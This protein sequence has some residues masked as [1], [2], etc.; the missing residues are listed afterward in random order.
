MTVTIRCLLPLLLMALTV[1]SAA[2]TYAIVLK[3]STA[4]RIRDAAVKYGEFTSVG[5]V[6]DPGVEK[7]HAGIREKP[8]TVV[9]VVWIAED[10]TAFRRQV[11]LDL[12]AGSNE[13]MFEIRR[14]YSVGVSARRTPM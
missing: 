5:G 3:N 8:P 10:G 6:L 14:D 2:P 9:E 7:V 13:I 11:R 12:P 4:G 1:C